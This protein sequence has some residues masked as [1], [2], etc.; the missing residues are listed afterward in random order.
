VTDWTGERFAWSTRAQILGGFVDLNLEHALAHPV[1]WVDRGIPTAEQLRKYID[2]Y[3][4][5][6]FIVR[7][8]DFGLPGLS[9]LVSPYQTIGDAKIYRS[10][11]P[12][13]YFAAGS[14]HV[15]ATTNRIDVTGTLS[16]ETIELKYHWHEALVCA[17]SCHVER[18]PTEADAVGFIRVP[19]PHPSDFSIQN[20][21]Q[22]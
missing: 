18:V 10:N 1:R 17:P 16:D 3:A 11:I 21:Y 13:S 4:V 2:T 8:G 9:Q 15:N 5:K 19:A 12:V 22:Y 14:G 6:Y 7:F 20:S